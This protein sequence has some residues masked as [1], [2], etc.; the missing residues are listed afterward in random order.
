MNTYNH[1]L[2]DNQFLS[3]VLSYDD[4]TRKGITLIN[5]GMGTGKTTYMTSGG[6]DE[7]CLF[8]VKAIRN[9]QISSTQKDIEDERRDAAENGTSSESRMFI[10]KQLEEFVNM[11]EEEII[12]KYKVIHLDEAHFIYTSSFRVQVVQRLFEMINNLSKHISIMLYSGT[13]DIE[14]SPLK[15]SAVHNA[16][17]ALPKRKL[18]VVVTDESTN[19]TNSIMVQTI[20]NA[21]ALYPELKILMFN[22]NN[23]SNTA[24]VEKLKEDGVRAVALNASSTAMTED[25]DTAETRVFN[26]IAEYETIGQLDVDVILATKCLEEGINIKDKVH[27]IATQNHPSSILQQFARARNS[28]GCMFTLLVN[29]GSKA[30]DEEHVAKTLGKINNAR[31]GYNKE[32]MLVDHGV[33]KTASQIADNCLRDACIN[34]EISNSM[35]NNKQLGQQ[36]IQDVQT[37]GEFDINEYFGDVV[38]EKPISTCHN[39]RKLVVE[40]IVEH[41]NKIGKTS[42]REL[43]DAVKKALGTK[44][45]EYAED[46][47]RRCRSFRDEWALLNVNIAWDVAYATLPND[48][49]KFFGSLQ[50]EQWLALGQKKEAILEVVKNDINKKINR[51]DRDLLAEKLI[52]AVSAFDDYSE[53]ENMSTACKTKI[54]KA[55][56]GIERNADGYLRCDNV[57]AETDWWLDT[58]ESKSDVRRYQRHTKTVESRDITIEQFHEM[59]GFKKSKVASMKKKEI[60]K[61]LDEVTW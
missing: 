13:F 10:S 57:V 7:L 14:N 39:N 12:S 43:L 25:Y 32:I 31:D 27:V 16:S 5:A 21:R 18:D 37:R 46:S 19:I 6:H 3:D 23:K 52:S 44:H 30:F 24:I 53:A 33:S 40:A 47:I 50:K 4:K 56:V 41:D 58:I 51:V 26:S 20:H 2:S 35:Y 22:N 28:E 36:V 48:A 1:K 60:T 45:N 61:I 9:Q 17:K 15:I 11:T 49:V 8:P 55:V 38:S 42:H 34:F 29:D 59:T 54:L